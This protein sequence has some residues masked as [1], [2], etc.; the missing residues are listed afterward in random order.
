MVK[1]AVSIPV[2]GNGDVFDR[3]DCRRILEKTGVH[4]NSGKMLVKLFGHNSSVYYVAF[5]PD[6]QTLATASEDN[7]ARL[8]SVTSGSMLKTFTEH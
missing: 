5:S 6:G 2:F 7:T 3:N 8:W 1:Q 4:V